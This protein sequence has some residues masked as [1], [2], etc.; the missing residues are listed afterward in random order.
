MSIVSSLFRKDKYQNAVSDN[1][2][3]GFVAPSSSGV[4]VTTDRALKVTTV[5]DCLRVIAEGVAQVPLKIY[6]S[7]G[8][9]SKE[10]A[11]DNPWYNI[12]ATKPNDWQTS[13]EFRENLV[14]QAGLT[15]N[16]YA[17]K[18]IVRGRPVSLIP[19]EPGTVTV[20]VNDRREVEY[21]V[22][23]GGESK[24][25][26]AS[27]IWHV[28][29][30][31][32]QTYVGMDATKYAREAIGL[33]INIE[34]AQNKL[35]ANG[36]QTSGFYSVESTLDQT[37]YKQL[38]D[39]IEKNIGGINK[40]RPFI[41]DRGAKF[42]PVSMTGVDAQTIENRRFQIEEICRA[43]RVMPIMIGQSD[44]AS[45]YASA[46][47]MFLAHVVHTLMPWMTRIEQSIDANL[48]I[49]KEREDGYYSKFNANGLMRGA[50]KDRAAFYWQMYQMKAL[51]P[52]EIRA[53]EE[54][55]PYEGG[56]KYYVAQGMESTQPSSTKGVDD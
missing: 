50:A 15:G 24:K 52:N 41:L 17:F 33:S 29:G 51:N 23:S 20:S 40:F 39:W 25:F 38:R 54:Y 12:L 43:F 9:D 48:L 31:S 55:N 56:D 4:N 16:F 36:V 26:P 11:K 32:W 14:F 19:F 34:D 35:H 44:K 5:F 53:L 1:S 30:P 2:M 37:Q 18:N 22:S 8:D 46:E 3:S 21:E 45:T 13:F 49:Q 7:T 47:Q 10:L 27:S 42:Q 6:K 28:R